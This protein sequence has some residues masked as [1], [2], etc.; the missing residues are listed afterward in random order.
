LRKFKIAVERREKMVGY[1]RRG[2]ESESDVDVGVP[3]EVRLHRFK[4]SKNGGRE[5]GKNLRLR[6]A[7]RGIR[8]LCWCRVT[9]EVRLHRFEKSLK[10]G[11]EAGKMLG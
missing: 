8:I 10:S 7:R 2:G 11:R 1:V 6:K 5:S 3:L 9:L 4:K